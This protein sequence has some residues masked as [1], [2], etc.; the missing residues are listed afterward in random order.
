[1]I[2]KNYAKWLWGWPAKFEKRMHRNGSVILLLG[3]YNGE[4]F[5]TGFNNPDEFKEFLNSSK[6]SGGIWTD[7][8]ELFGPVLKSTPSLIH[9]YK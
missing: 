3:D 4:G 6:Y 9:F 7:H 8:I 5:S 2:P 1:M